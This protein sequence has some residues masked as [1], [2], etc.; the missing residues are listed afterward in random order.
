VT[1]LFSYGTLRDAEYQHALFD[2]SMAMRPA[3]LAGWRIV[4]AE[5]GYLTIVPAPGERIAGD[6]IALDAADLA[7]ADGWEGPE[8]LRI[9]VEAQASDGSPVACDVYVRPTARSE[10]TPV[11]AL[12]GH[13]REH[14]LAEIR[15]FRNSRRV[16]PSS[17]RD[18][19][20]RGDGSTSSP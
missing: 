12:A 19:H 17:S 20:D 7:C 11:G 6:V 14:V 5:S 10:A 8:Y 18:G 1:L 2:R 4:V 16:M 15:A 3:T 13:R 9:A